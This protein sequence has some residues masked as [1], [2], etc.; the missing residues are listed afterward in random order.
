MTAPPIDP[1]E[2]LPPIPTNPD[3]PNREPSPD[4]PVRPVGPGGAPT[5]LELQIRRDRIRARF[6]R[7]DDVIS[8]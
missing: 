2:P 1:A 6:Y 4:D 8:A 3:E 7:V 5:H